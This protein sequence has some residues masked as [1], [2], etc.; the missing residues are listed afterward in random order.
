MTARQE[1]L[2]ALGGITEDNR[3]TP[4][5]QEKSQFTVHNHIWKTR[6]VA[7]RMH[8]Q[9]RITPDA[10]EAAKRWTETFILLHDGPHALEQRGNP[11]TIKHDRISWAMTQAK[12]KDSIAAIREYI[13]REYHNLLVMT[14][15]DCYSSNAV[16]GM[17]SG[18]SYGNTTLVKYIDQECIK[19]YEKL[20]E[21]Y[22]KSYRRGVRNDKD[23]KG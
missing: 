22:Q 5:R 4:E 3:P 1:I 21:F 20:S 2:R 18:L 14:L 8:N 17:F 23:M 16:A 13:G 10:F 19:A 15:Y 7:E 6:T 9:E 11:S 12:R